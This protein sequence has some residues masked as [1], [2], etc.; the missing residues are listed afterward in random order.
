[1]TLNFVLTLQTVVPKLILFSVLMKQ[2]VLPTK[3]SVVLQKQFS[4][5]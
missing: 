5:C 1:M 4:L 3:P 2:D